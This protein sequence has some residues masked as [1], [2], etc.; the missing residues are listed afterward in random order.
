MINLTPHEVVLFGPEPPLRLPAAEHPARII[1]TAVDVIEIDDVPVPV[2]R[3]RLGTVIDGLPDCTE[4]VYY[5][6]SRAVAMAVAGRPDLL[7]PGALHTRA[8]GL[9]GCAELLCFQRE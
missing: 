6:V 5:V 7:V 3:R 2:Q 1:D 8:D 9:I 4:G